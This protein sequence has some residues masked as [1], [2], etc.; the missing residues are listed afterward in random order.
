M[1]L[2]NINNRPILYMKLTKNSEYMEWYQSIVWKKDSIILLDGN[3]ILKNSY[4]TQDGFDSNSFNKMLKEL[5]LEKYA[6]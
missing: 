5:Y 2:S 1:K 3:R 6:K 4:V